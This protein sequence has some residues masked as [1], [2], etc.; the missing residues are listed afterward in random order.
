M[1]AWSRCP[2]SASP[3]SLSCSSQRKRSRPTSPTSTCPLRRRQ[4]TASRPPRS[5][6]IRD[7]ELSDDEAKTIRGFRF[8]T[9][10]PV[11]VLLNI[12]EG[13]I[14]RSA[15]VVKKIAD[16]YHHSHSQVEALSAKIEMEIGQLDPEEAAIFRS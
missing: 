14:A 5:R 2:T 13:D 7:V 3:S 8:L 6:P 10:K 4:R 11:L 9:E 16:Q 1:S 12:G 15:E